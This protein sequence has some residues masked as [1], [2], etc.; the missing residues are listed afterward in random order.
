MVN[1]VSPPKIAR[2]QEFLHQPKLDDI[3]VFPY[4]LAVVWQYF[5]SLPNKTAGWALT[6]FVSLGIWYVY[7]L[8]KPRDDAALTRWFWA[9]LVPPLIFIFVLRVL[10]PDTSWDVLNY[11]LFH[12]ER[13]LRGPLLIPGDFFPT[14]APF[15]PAPDILTGLYRLVLGYR[16]GTIANLIAVVWLGIIMDRLLRYYVRKAWLRSVC[17][18]LILC[19]EQIFFQINNYMVDLLTLPLLLEATLLAV[20]RPERASEDRHVIVVALLL[21]IS[22]TFKLANIAFAIP[23]ALICAF[24]LFRVWRELEFGRFIKIS[25]IS[26]IAAVAP[27]VPFSIFLY[28]STGSPVFPLYNAIFKSP[29]WRA[30]N[31]FDPRWGP[32]GFVETLLWPLLVFFKPERFCEFPVYS[33]RLSLGFITALVCIPLAKKDLTIRGLCLV[34]VLAAFLWSAATGYSRYGIFIE[35]TSGA[36]LVWFIVYLWKTFSHLRSPL[37]W[38]PSIAVSCLLLAQAAMALEYSAHHEWS[39]RPTL[40]T[41]PETLRDAK[42]VLRDRNVTTGLSEEERASIANVDVW[43]ASNVKTTAFMGLLRPDIPVINA[44]QWEYISTR[45]ARTA[46]NAL[47]NA[48]ANRRLY[49]LCFPD[50]LAHA[51]EALESRGLTISSAQPIS[52]PFFSPSIRIALN[53]LR[54]SRDTPIYRAQISLQETLT[55]FAPGEKKTLTLRIKNTGSMLWRA[56]V[57]AEGRLQVNASD[58]WLAEDSETVVNDMDARAALPHDLKSGEEVGLQLNVTA[59]RTPGNYIL[60]IDMVHEGVAFFYEKNSEPLRLKVRVEP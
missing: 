29:F 27:I 51:R 15:N 19:T 26:L 6:A 14:P 35:L 1:S 56:Y 11:H 47:T 43:V 55:R 18:V 31:I 12:S 25:V 46:F 30:S 40:L 48:S 28:S 52:V 22:I 45:T 10:V 41:R 13:A 60:E 23:I 20:R 59:P 39:T 34:T 50:D 9:I 33:G 17:V 32:K 58:T 24:N 8:I 5:W 57:S 7:V 44:L 3:F 53:L 21:G 36:I 49:S 42:L 38:L 54:I 4:V 2:P 37:R 16:L